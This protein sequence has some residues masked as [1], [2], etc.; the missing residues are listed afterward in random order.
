MLKPFTFLLGCLPFVYSLYQVYLLQTG[1]PNS[2]GADPGKA[3]VH[4]QGEWA[5]RFLLLTL[6]VTPVRKFPGLADLIRIRRMLGLF[7]FFYAAMH[8]LAYS[9]F[10][11]LTDLSGIAADIAKRPYITVGF[12]AFVLLIPLAVTS[13]DGMIRRLKRRWKQLHSM[14]YVVAVLVVI[15]LAWIAKSSYAEPVF[16]GFLMAFLLGYRLWTAR[17]R[18]LARFGSLIPGRA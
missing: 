14:I 16:Y 2:L 12:A 9:Q 4:F 11:L 17:K 13:T 15:H 7:A 10:L 3:L 5:L 1:Q 8:L 6:L 18:L